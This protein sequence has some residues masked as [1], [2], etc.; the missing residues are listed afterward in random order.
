MST[1]NKNLAKLLKSLSHD[2][3]PG[4]LIEDFHSKVFQGETLRWTAF[5]RHIST[6]LE[7]DNPL[8]KEFILSDFPVNLL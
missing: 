4:S 2:D 5:V 8:A 3:Q 1:S 6:T 7:C